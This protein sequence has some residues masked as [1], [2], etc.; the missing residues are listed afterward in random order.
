MV[1][2]SGS[3]PTRLDAVTPSARTLPV[4]MCP[5]EPGKLSNN[6]CDRGFDEKNDALQKLA[7]LIA[8]IVNP[9]DKSN[10]VDIEAARSAHQL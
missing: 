8:Q 5:I 7:V 4:L 2:T 3:A 6:I 10:V 9:P 1:G